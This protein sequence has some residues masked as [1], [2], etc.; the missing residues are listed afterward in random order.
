MKA[1]LQDNRRYILRFDK[2]ESVF[3]ELSAFAKDNQIQAA[4]FEGVGSASEIKLGYYNS[5]LKEYRAKPFVENLEIISLSGNLSLNGNDIAIHAHGSFGRTDF[6]MIGGHVFGITVLATCEIF[7]IKLE[8]K[9]ER[10][11]DSELKLNLLT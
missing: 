10:K 7:L 5:F 4:S 3:S 2:G 9:M 6:T 11:E 1:V 8:G